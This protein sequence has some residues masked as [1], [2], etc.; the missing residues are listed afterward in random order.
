MNKAEYD[1]IVIGAGSAGLIVAAEAV[2]LGAKVLLVEE[3]KMGG[4]CL[5]YGCVPSKSLLKSAHLWQEIKNANTWGLDVTSKNVDIRK[6]MGYVHK[7]IKAIEPHDSK[8][9]FE[10]LGVAVVQGRGVLVD[11]NTVRINQ[12]NYSCKNIVVATGSLPHIPK[13]KGLEHIDY[14]TNKT[15]FEITILP[16]HLVVIGAGPV[17]LELGQAI[18]YLGSDVTIIDRNK[19]LL[20]N[21]DHE[22]GKFLADVFA[23]E[24]I[25]IKY[26]TQIKEIKTHEKQIAVVLEAKGVVS[27]IVCDKIL[28]AAGRIPFSQNLGLENLDIPT[29]EKGFIR[30]NNKMQTTIK[31]IYACGDVTGPYLYTQTAFYQ[32]SIVINNI[33]HKNNSTLKY[34]NVAWCT[35]TKPEV[36]HV[37]YTEA[38]AKEKGLHHKSIVTPLDEND[39]AIC[40]NE[41]YGFLKLV[42]GK[43][44]KILGA[45]MVAEK[46]GELI[47]FAALAVSQQM[48][49][50]DFL[51]VMLPY[52]TKAEIYKTIA[53]QEQKNSQA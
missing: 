47:A 9:T 20:K 26:E 11:A 40:E 5:N 12:K 49:I 46:A 36:A 1:I 34:N 35:Y 42:L 39:R 13:I 27:E 38:Q 17:G 15:I 30:T 45:T 23:K 16:K 32:A 4:D 29:D 50:L 51:N 2:H 3:E 19:S 44:D 52:P 37:G 10:K 21:D 25:D 14:L 22:A 48:K 6:V 7:K 53:A 33:F 8:E 24:E 31:N 28:V 41:N 43:D 18:K